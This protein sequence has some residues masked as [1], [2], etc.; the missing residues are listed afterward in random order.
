MKLS[1]ICAAVLAVLLASTSTSA[2][3]FA[4]ATSVPFGDSAIFAPCSDAD[5]FP[6]LAGSLCLTDSV[7]LDPS[8]GVAGGEAAQLFVRKFPADKAARRRGEIWLIAG[9][10]GESGASFYPL[11]PTLR[12]AF[13]G[14]DLI[15]P[16]HR[17]TGYSTKICAVEEAPDSAEGIALAGDEWGPCIGNAYVDPVRAKSF[18][19]THAAQDLSA[20]IGRH[21][22][23]GRTYVYGV[24]YGTQLVLRMMA[25]SPVKVDGLILDGLVPQDGTAEADLGRRTAIVDTVGRSLLTADEAAALTRVLAKPDIW[26]AAVPGGDL[27][28]AMGSL[29]NFPA[30]RARIPAIVAALDRGDPAPMTQALGDLRGEAAKLGGFAQSPSSVPLVI[31]ISGSENNARRDLS[32]ETVAKEA[33]AALFTSPLPGLLAVPPFPL[34]DRD[35]WYGKAPARLPPTLVMQGTLD[36]N[37][38]YDAARHHAAVLAQAGKVRFAAVEGGAHFLALVA[39]DCFVGLSQAF[40]RGKRVAARCVAAD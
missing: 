23:P 3:S 18:T 19:V 13:P 11:L 37:T 33:E 25:A 35:G 10:P 31:L 30:L 21:R 5:R 6:A 12:R 34:Y 17:G 38:P 26:R 16:D 9:G 32:P 28:Q 20:L 24:S 7:A 29:L 8:A 1:T 15:V 39:P 36:P 2:S 22:G 4:A 40:V 14:L 27:R